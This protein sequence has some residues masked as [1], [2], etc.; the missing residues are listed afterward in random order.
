MGVIDNGLAC[1]CIAIIPDDEQGARANLV[2]A[3]ITRE[4]PNGVPNRP[5]LL[6]SKIEALQALLGPGE[7]DRR[8]RY[9]L[10]PRTALASSPKQ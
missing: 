3:G 6:D 10:M 2:K 7:M 5:A 4:M 9:H 8:V 1:L